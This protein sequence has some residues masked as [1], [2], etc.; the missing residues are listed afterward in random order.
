MHRPHKFPDAISAVKFI[1]WTDTFRSRGESQPMVYFRRSGLHHR[2]FGHGGRH[3][4]GARISLLR[5]GAAKVGS[6]YDMGLH[7]L[8]FRHYF[9]MVF[10]GL[11][12]G[13]F[14]ARDKRLHWRSQALWSDEHARCPESWLAVDSGIIV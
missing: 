4:T 6:Y 8:V 7:G 13:L 9:P 2:G 1:S 3:D 12:T 14:G 11:F 10:L 5:S